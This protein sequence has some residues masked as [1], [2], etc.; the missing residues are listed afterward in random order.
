MLAVAFTVAQGLSF[1]KIVLFMTQCIEFTNIGT[2]FCRQ[3]EMLA[4]LC[5]DQSDRTESRGAGE[6][7]G[8]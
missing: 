5:R 7:T 6:I 4:V 8:R 1:E 2:Y 3:A